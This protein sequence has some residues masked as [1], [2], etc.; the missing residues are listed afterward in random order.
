M[1]SCVHS[2]K[3]CWGSA[4]HCRDVP[5]RARP[6]GPTARRV[7]SPGAASPPARRPPRTC[8]AP[9]SVASAPAMPCLCASAGPPGSCLQATRG[10]S[11]MTC[12][13]ASQDRAPWIRAAETCLLGC[14]SIS[15]SANREHPGMAMKAC[16]DTTL[17]EYRPLSL[18]LPMPSNPWAFHVYALSMPCQNGRGCKHEIAAGA[19][20]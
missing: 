3:P 16:R 1:Q 15:A 14:L 12:D 11:S 6:A 4:M 8:C 2:R 19:D 9:W 5:G 13:H 7:R 20:L 18:P 17:W 10:R